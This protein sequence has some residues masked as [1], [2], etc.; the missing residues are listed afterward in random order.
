MESETSVQ[1]SCQWMQWR[2]DEC[3]Q[4]V[5]QQEERG[6]NIVRIW[7]ELGILSQLKIAWSLSSL[8][9]YRVVRRARRSRNKV[10]KWR[11]KRGIKIEFT[12]SK[13]QTSEVN[14]ST[15]NQM[16]PSERTSTGCRYLRLLMAG[17]PSES[18]IWNIEIVV[19]FFNPL[20]LWDSCLKVTRQYQ[21][22]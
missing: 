13:N 17:C 14:N 6:L 8:R 20:V 2:S 10:S 18:W 15:K 9:V 21:P 22:R 16:G 12:K 3:S 1:E 5:Q 11:K 19:K 7:V 4:I